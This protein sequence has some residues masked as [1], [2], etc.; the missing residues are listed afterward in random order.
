MITIKSDENI[1]KRFD[2]AVQ[3]FYAKLGNKVKKM[4]SSQS[5]NLLGNSKNYYFS[6]IS[7]VRKIIGRKVKITKQKQKTFVKII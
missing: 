4:Q 3:E 5:F 7:Q 6:F 2:N 1:S